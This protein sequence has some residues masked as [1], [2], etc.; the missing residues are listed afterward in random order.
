[1]NVRE[2]FINL[3]KRLVPYGKEIEF[4]SEYLP[5]NILKKDPVGNLY[6]KI[7]ESNT[8]FA[9]H[10]DTVG[11][12]KEV[13][14]IFKG[15]MVE[16]D[17]KSQLGGD[18]KA[19]VTIMLYMIHS[20][21]PG[22]Y[23]FFMGEEVGCKGSRALSEWIEK[24]K[25]DERYK[26]INKVVSFDRKDY[27][28]VI[29]YQVSE[30]S[31]SDEFADSLIKEL[32]KHKGFTYRKDQGGI[33]TDSV[34]FTDVY[35]E[36][37]NLSVGYFDQHMMREKQD[38]SFLEKLAKASC[39][40]NWDGLTI[41]RKP[42]ETEK[43]YKSYGGHGN[44]WNW[45]DEYEY[46]YGHGGRTYPS[47]GVGFNQ[48]SRGQSA[49]GFQKDWRGDQVPAKDAVYCEFDNVW[50]RRD[51]AI[52]VELLGFYTT[53]DEDTPRKT[54]K[55]T[56]TSAAYSLSDGDVIDNTNKVEVGER[57]VHQSFGLGVVKSIDPEGKKLVVDFDNG[58][59]KALLLAIAKL[60]KDVT[61]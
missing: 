54:P 50:C 38:L 57:V 29:T 2:T 37:T 27:Y 11:G 46:G 43:L 1:M 28:S 23:T 52:W 7:G 51:E 44:A 32:N 20:G 4:L 10:L 30:R 26:D 21:V 60:K 53:P 61:P 14:H 33:L 49:T 41:K 34:H 59:Q 3:T 17:G 12:D 5:M 35:A 48:T 25:T 22:L 36:C 8:M 6:I 16:T 55:T 40:V 13:T 56:S 31:C 58:Q 15:D 19:G 39:E 9:S 24:N 47:R 18:D 42:G 45:D